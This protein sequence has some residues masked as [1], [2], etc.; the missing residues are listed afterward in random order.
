[1]SQQQ[2][3]QGQQQQGGGGGQ[4]M[5]R[6]RPRSQQMIQVAAAVAAGGSLLVLSA[7]MLAGTV[8]ALTLATPLVVIFSPVLVPATITAFLIMLGFVASCGFGMA[9]LAVL[10]WMYKYI[11][12]Q[13]PPGA[14]QLD[15]ARMKLAGKAREM[16][17]RAEQFRQQHITGSQQVS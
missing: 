11:N 8:V 1:M 17:E 9:A 10:S 4:M 16:K 7:L 6:D 15:N 12:G 2:R 13:H 14:D 3:Q 5:N